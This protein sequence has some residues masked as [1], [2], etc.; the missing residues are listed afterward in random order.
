LP[1]AQAENFLFSLRKLNN[2]SFV[3]KGVENITSQIIPLSKPKKERIRGFKL[4]KI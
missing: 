3:L 1:S 4:N 2:Y